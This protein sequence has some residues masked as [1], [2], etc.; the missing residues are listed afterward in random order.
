MNLVPSMPF[1]PTGQCLNF[2]EE[3]LAE[4]AIP[5]EVRSGGKIH[6]VTQS[7]IYQISNVTAALALSALMAAGPLVAMSAGS[8]AL[9][10]QAVQNREK[11]TFEV[12]VLYTILGSKSWWNKIT[13]Y[14]ILGAIPLQHQMEE[15]KEEGVEAVLTLVEPHELQPG[16]I[17]PIS[18]ENWVEN[19]IM[20]EQI[21]A[22]DYVGMPADQI[23]AAVEFI[24]EQ[25][26]QKKTVF[27]HCKAGR[28]RSAT[29]VIA[30][31]SLYGDRGLPSGNL[32]LA[33]AYV[34]SRRPQIN[35]NPNQLFALEAWADLYRNP[36][37]FEV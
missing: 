27:V 25:V 7:C 15:I 34:K 32:E 22:N 31:L 9:G 28:G 10:F 1:N 26:D 24:K 35:L 12:S 33:H 14:I 30:Y 21:P 16:L 17:N 23:Q 18:P 37:A 29:A 4:E 19:A 3:S 2:R 6:S 5:K 13:D 20:H 36:A 8:L 11:L